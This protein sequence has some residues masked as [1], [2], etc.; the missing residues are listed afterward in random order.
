MKAKYLLIGFVLLLALVNT[1]ETGALTINFETLSDLE[2][3]TTQFTGLGVTFSNATALT[4][5]ISLN[6]LEFPPHSGVNVVFDD[7]GQMSLTFSTP[8][9]DFGAYFTYL[10]PLTLS[11][12]NSLSNLEGTVTSAFS[13]NFVSSGNPP[14][15]FLSFVWA[16]GISSVVITG[17]PGGGSFV[18]DDLT[19][20]SANPVPEPGTLL[21]LGSGVLGMA[22][23][24]LKR[25]KRQG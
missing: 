4:A 18:M 21:L 16:S 24:G 23:Y 9:A 11:F 25:R 8:M 7:G 22:G 13:S 3:V 20:T 1:T 6:E 15:E 12:F 14:N 10:A 19:A 17:D 2:V 5:G